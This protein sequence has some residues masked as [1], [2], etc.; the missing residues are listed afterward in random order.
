MNSST[1]RGVILSDQYRLSLAVG[2]LVHEWADHTRF[3]AAA[4]E[5]DKGLIK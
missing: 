1:C 3:A 2:L 5:T 4:A